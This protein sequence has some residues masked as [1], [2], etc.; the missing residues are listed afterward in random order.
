M[1][2]FIKYFIIM[3]LKVAVSKRIKDLMKERELNQYQLSKL[4]CIP[5]ST[6]STILHGDAKTTTF[7]NIYYICRGLGIE[8][9]EFCASEYFASEN[10][11]D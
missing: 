6:L 1:I 11:D 4:S 8:L 3:K 9:E 5:Q 7:L 10:I 2:E